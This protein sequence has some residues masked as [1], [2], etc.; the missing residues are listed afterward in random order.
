MDSRK[1]KF[2]KIMDAFFSYS[3]LKLSIAAIYNIFRLDCVMNIIHLRTIMWNL[4]Y[5]VSNVIMSSIDAT[6]AR[7]TISRKQVLWMK[8]RTFFHLLLAKWAI[9]HKSN[10]LVMA[11]SLNTRKTL[12]WSFEKIGFQIG[13]PAKKLWRKSVIWTHFRLR[14]DKSLYTLFEIGK[15]FCQKVPTLEIRSGMKFFTFK[16]NWCAISYLI[17][18]LMPRDYLFF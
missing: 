2:D 8:S 18:N 4:I 12:L 5:S 11:D 13:L 9:F 17:F 3:R 1:L 16:K 14:W 10:G 6:N 7:E 15:C